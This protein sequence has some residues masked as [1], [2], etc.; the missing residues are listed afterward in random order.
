MRLLVV[1]AAVAIQVHSDGSEVHRT[2]VPAR[3]SA[4][5]PERPAPTLKLA[6]GNPP[7]SMRSGSS[8]TGSV[9]LAS[10]ALVVAVVALGV[11]VPRRRRT[12]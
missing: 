11:A 3:G 8:Q 1:A 4:V 7:A 10:I 5:E 2:D 9:V 6:L 12:T